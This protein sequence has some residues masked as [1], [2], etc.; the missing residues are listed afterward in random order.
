MSRAKGR[1][2]ITAE[3]LGIRKLKPEQREVISRVLGRKDA[4]A[5]FPVGFGKSAIIQIPALLESEHPT[6]VF[7]PTISL[8]V[9]QVQTLKSKGIKAEYISSWNKNEHAE[10]YDAYVNG[11]ITILYVAPERLKS[12]DFR[13]AV[14]ANPPWLVAVD[15]AH[16]VLEWGRS[17]RPDYLSI[18]DF[19]DGMDNRPTVLALTATAPTE[20]RDAIA[21]LLHMRRVN[22]YTASLARP[23]LILIRERMQY[24]ELKSRFRHVE[25][26]LKKHLKGGRAI[27]YCATKNETDMFFNYLS[28]C[29]ESEIVECHSFMDEA[30]RAENEM[31]FISGERR[32]MVATTA[33]GMGIDVPDIRLIIHASLPISP[34]SYYQEIGRAGRDGGKSRCILLYHPKDTKKF[35]PIIENEE[36]S[37]VQEQLRRGI[38]DMLSIAEGNQCI[39][40]ALLKH[41]DD[42]DPRPCGQCSVCQGKRQGKSPA[43]NIERIDTGIDTFEVSINKLTYSQVQKIRKNLEK[44]DKEEGAYHA[45]NQKGATVKYMSKALAP[46]GLNR[47][48]TFQSEKASNIQCA[49]NPTTLICDTFQPPKLYDPT[50][51]LINDGLAF[52]VLDILREHQ[53]EDVPGHEITESNLHPSQIDVTRNLWFDDDVNFSTLITLFYKSKV[54]GNF[55]RDKEK[56][57]ESEG[58]YFCA[59][60]DN[61]ATIKAYDKIAHLR[62]K[63]QLPPELK[64]KHILRLEVSMKRD[65]FIQKLEV[66]RED[67]LEQMLTA[68]YRNAGEII[69]DFLLKLFPCDADHYRY[70][71]AVQ[72]V[73]KKVKK[74]GLRKRMLFLLERMG[75]EAFN[76]L[77]QACR[78][79]SEHFDL[80]SEEMKRL[81]KKFDKIGV[82]PITLPNRSEIPKIKN[83]RRMI[84]D[85]YERAKP[86]DPNK[87]LLKKALEPI[88]PEASP[89]IRRLGP[90]QVPLP[91]NDKTNDAPANSRDKDG[92]IVLHRK[93]PNRDE[94]GF[95][96]LHRRENDS[97]STK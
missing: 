82:N 5:I 76:G 33:F 87:A 90:R 43:G 68:A 61:Y 37:D 21:Q 2:L 40:Q 66:S 17:F 24:P 14:R 10:I 50:I 65:Y 38:E 12:V 25:T 22:V 62:R 3:K 27:V 88:P 58:R 72:I 34:V 30:E 16:C 93:D 23:N 39:M 6:I 11:D 49:V 18:G 47:I 97:D 52:S 8:M 75:A 4:F 64:D 91:G 44:L 19:V 73:K 85:Y 13:T 31:L 55:K 70:E 41:L 79:T 26:L 71:D 36:R 35:D 28:Q 63:G 54:P 42:Q 7:E 15:E 59:I 78:E 77:D 56:M 86:A 94:Q 53:L 57:Q 83:I 67:R 69:D 48:R 9:D 92:F 74:D 80:S 29:Y 81:L 60:A 84:A 89:M 20:Y 1:T 96:V 46:L 51:E 45:P 95:Y 32:I